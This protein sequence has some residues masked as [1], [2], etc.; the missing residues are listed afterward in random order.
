MNPRTAQ[1]ARFDRYSMPATASRKVLV[2]GGGPGGM[3]AA[4][5]A[6]E[7]GH[8]VTLAEKTQALGGLL[9]FTD[10]DALKVDLKRLKDYLICQVNKCGAEVRL[11]TE[12]TPE[13]IRAGGF[14]AVILAV[15]SA[16]AMPPI[17][18]LE[19][20]RHATEIYTNGET[21]GQ[22]VAVLGG[23]LVGCET[24]IYL[25][26]NGHEVTIIEMQDEIA[27]EANWM[28]KEGMRQAI[29]ALPILCKTGIKV[30]KITSEK[31][32][33]FIDKGGEKG[34][35]QA[36]SVVYALGMRPNGALVN[37]LRSI[38]A[39]TCAVGDCVRARK[40]RHA[41]EE[42]YWAAVRLG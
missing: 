14:D 6:A 31:E 29:E 41:M 3:K 39:D 25:A 17:P 24:G 27:P 26:Q 8:Q 4:I 21:M 20:A 18:G 28:H 13:Y 19:Y 11:N 16:P 33:H 35:L 34:R 2:V 5:T 30:E 7:R 10:Y 42:G 22:S 36:D 12:V 38:C 23:G 1:E 15:G 40:A 32:I 37:Q 9:K